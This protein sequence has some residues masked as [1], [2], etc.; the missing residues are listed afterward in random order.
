[1]GSR[2]AA[3]VALLLITACQLPGPGS[4]C[5]AQIDWVDFIQVGSV[6]YLARPDPA[7]AIQE[8]DL[9]P[10][11]SRVKFKVSGHVC[12][13]SYRPKDGDAA[14]MDVGTPIYQVNG[15]PPTQRLAVRARGGLVVY[16]PGAPSQP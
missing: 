13:P 16:Q 14:F 9:G 10:V 7:D 2:L 1:M 12:D 6:Q 8:G 11:Y 3:A 15:F 5:T 4:G